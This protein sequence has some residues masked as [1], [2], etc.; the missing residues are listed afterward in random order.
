[1]MIMKKHTKNILYVAAAFAL[2]GCGAESEHGE[3][4]D[5]MH[6]DEH[7]MT[8]NEHEHAD[9]MNSDSMHDM[10]EG[11]NHDSHGIMEK[12]EDARLVT[13]TATEYEFSPSEITTNPNEKL[14]VKLVNKGKEVHMWQLRGKPETHIHTPAGKTA[15]KVIVAPKEPGEYE[16]FCATSGHEGRGM[17]GILKVTSEM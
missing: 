6:H 11:M 13:V 15:G 10:H 16:I 7:A 9:H 12:P 8:M 5:T 1:M 17:V 4:H 3:A 2:A 14:F